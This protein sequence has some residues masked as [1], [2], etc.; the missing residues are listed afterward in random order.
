[1]ITRIRS[2]PQRLAPVTDLAELKTESDVEQKLI[3]PFLCHPSYLALPS[4]WVRTKEYMEPTPIDKGSGKRSGYIPDYSIWKRGFPLAIVEAKSPDVRVEVALREARLY[5]TELNKRY[6]PDINPV[7]YILACNG[8]QFALSKWDSETEVLVAE[9][10]EVQPGTALLAAFQNTFNLD[11]LEKLADALS[12]KF[13]ARRFHTVASIL[14]GPRIYEQLGVNAFAQ[15]LFPIVTRY[16]GSESDEASDDIIDRGY[17]STNERSEYNAVLEAYLK[18]RARVVAS[19]GLQAIETDRT[20][21]T[22]LSSEM[23]RY[24]QNPT[25]YGRVQLVVGAVGSGKSLFIRRFYR[26]LLPRDIEGR[27]LWAFINFN[28]YDPDVGMNAWVAEQFMESFQKLNDIDLGELGLI[29]KLF[30]RELRQ[31]ERGP[32]KLLKKDSQEYTR[33][34]YFKL[35]E[36][37]SDKTKY[38]EVI[39]RHFQGERRQGIVC[40]LDNVDRRSRDEQLA[41]FAAA[42]WFKN[43]TRALVIVNL[44]DSTFEAHRD[45]PPLDAFINALNFYIRPPRFAEV[46]RKRLEIVLSQV[47]DEEELAKQQRYQLESGA[48]ISYATSR[49][50]KFLMSIYLSLFER[51]DSYTRAALESLVA[52]NVRRA[53]GMFADILSSPHIP[54]SQITTTVL[55]IG[56]ERIAENNILRALM[57]GRYRLFNNR[58]VYIRNILSVNPDWK[59]PNNFLYA[60]L[61]EFLIR[62][63]KQKIDF[64]LEGYASGQ[65]IVNRMTQLGYEED[66]ALQALNQLAEWGLVE[67]ESLLTKALDRD[68]AVQVHA[69][70]FIHMR[71]LLMQP[72]YIVGIST[73]LAVSS[74]NLSSDLASVWTNPRVPEPEFVG[75]KRI[76]DLIH[77]YIMTEYDRRVSR[78]AFY[79]ELGYGGQIVVESLGRAA[80]RHQQTFKKKPSS[81][82]KRTLLRRR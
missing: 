63:R 58:S 80:R 44:R 3:Y 52:R 39:A 49:L 72:E 77:E 50:G 7:I 8:V 47:R 19:G 74:G 38:V 81:D 60:D 82:E 75:R 13:R 40:V 70:G 31:F 68:D 71:Y 36:L 21:A 51:R 11:Q 41:V 61:L 34:Q 45:E 20:T 23:R 59:R 79:R 27:T 5:A 37:T 48:S 69:S 4:E 35:Q 66:D 15:E 57:R 18:D 16:F 26:R 1:L 78:H 24:A 6:P 42:Q 29:E 12:N 33:Q 73:D 2:L 30:A 43:L 67:P 54:T 14:G 53:L 62:N 28:D 10:A 25:F 22:G 76:I 56:E 65:T 46:I 9:V 32:V 64:S 17:V 55:D